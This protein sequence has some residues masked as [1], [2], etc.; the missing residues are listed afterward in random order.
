MYGRLQ[1]G[2]GDA[3]SHDDSVSI[4]S[5]ANLEAGRRFVE[6]CSPRRSSFTEE[7]EL[8][9]LKAPKYFS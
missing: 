6:R 3:W 9:L 5:F 8:C 7:H 1:E 4:W 2:L